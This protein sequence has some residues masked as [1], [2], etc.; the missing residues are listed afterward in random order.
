VET[1]STNPVFDA[2]KKIELQLESTKVDVAKNA[3]GTVA[4][5]VRV[6]KG[7]RETAKLCRTLVKLTIGRDKELREAKPKRAKKEK[8]EQKAKK[9]KKSAAP[10]TA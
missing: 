2:F 7:L 9:E 6:R 3:N 5:G 10:Q 8:A 4:A 1:T